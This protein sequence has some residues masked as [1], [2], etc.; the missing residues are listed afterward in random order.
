[1][2]P[3]L[4]ASEIPRNPV[5]LSERVDPIGTGDGKVVVTTGFQ[6]GRWLEPGSKRS[7]SAVEDEPAAPAAMR[8]NPDGS[9]TAVW[10]PRA[11][12]M[13]GAAVH[14]FFR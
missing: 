6:A 14:L 10:C 12:A 8:M 5:P 4:E 11:L 1:M 9:R 13:A 2:L 7:H 3:P